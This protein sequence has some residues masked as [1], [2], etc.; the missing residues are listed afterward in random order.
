MHRLGAVE[1]VTD[2]TPSAAVVSAVVAAPGRRIGDPLAAL[3]A[4]LQCE[5]TE[6]RVAPPG[7]VIAVWGPTGAP[8]RTT[9]AVTLA[10]EAALLGVETLLVDADTYGGSVAQALGLLDE[11]PGL[12]AAA[13]AANSGRRT[14]P[15]L[16]L[17]LGLWPRDCASSRDSHVPKLA[18]AALVCA[19][20]GPR[21]GT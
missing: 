3:E 11:A 9:V 20:D 17:Q 15:P 12:A 8:G 21:T 1:V 5:L 16:L 13:R 7:M 10:V 18:G 6:Q 4:D 19:A 14:A 2:G